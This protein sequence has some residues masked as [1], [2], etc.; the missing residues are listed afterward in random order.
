MLSNGM[1]ACEE[2]NSNN[3]GLAAASYYS[4]FF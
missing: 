3:F 1:P 4:F 2:A